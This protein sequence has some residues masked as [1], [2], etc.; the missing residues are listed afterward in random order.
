MS[1]Q[2][3][4]SFVEVYRSGTISDAARAL[5]LT[6]P[7]VS[8]HIAALETQLG[9]KLF[10]RQ[11]RGMTSTMLADDLAQQVGDGLDRAEAALS[12]M[13]ARSVSLTG[14][15]H[16]AGPAELMAEHVAPHLSVLWQA[17]LQI[18]MQFG[19]RDALYQ[20]LLDGR[21][22]LAFTA[23]TPSDTQLDHLGIGT[24]RLMLVAAPALAQQ[25]TEARDLKA[26]LREMDHVAYDTDRP[27]IRSWCDA[28]EI[29]LVGTV[30]AVIAPDI[31]AL[32][33]CA[34]A[35]AGWSIMP[36]YLCARS[37]EAGTLQQVQAP[38]RTPQNQFYLVWVKSA[39]RHPRV[40]FARQ[41][42]LT[43]LQGAPAA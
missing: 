2:N 37:L 14:T 33:A 38:T 30:P 6:Q 35:G 22:D 8:Q 9:R 15:V 25:L 34:E 3:L 26:A 29:D 7:A 5:G 19:G 18:R 31:R 41:K 43:A 21:V 42:L 4:R 28:N 12:T 40:A 24:E 1:L 10:T 11:S 23:S 20:M 36:D 16:I 39:L 32:R 17:G 27:L 13:K